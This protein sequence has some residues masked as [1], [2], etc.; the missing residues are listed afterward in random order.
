[1]RRAL[2]RLL[3]VA[4]SLGGLFGAHSLAFA[5]AAPHVHD[6]AELLAETGHGSLIPVAIAVVTSLLLAFLRTSGSGWSQLAFLQVCGFVALEGAERI[7]AHGF[8]ELFV[9]PVFYLGLVLQ[10]VV[11][12]LAIALVRAA[13]TVARLLSS[14]SPFARRAVRPTFA[15][16]SS[17]RYVSKVASEAWNLRGPP[18]PLAF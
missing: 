18:S 11:S 7:G 2:S 6:R 16:V 13:K 1:M 3:L 5:F 12:L 4:L 17:I 9:E 8:Q 10:L 15:F 14:A